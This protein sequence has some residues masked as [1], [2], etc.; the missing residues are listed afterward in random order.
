MKN[1]KTK[2]FLASL[3]VGTLTIGMILPTSLRSHAEDGDV[4]AEILQSDI[5]NTDFDE[6]TSEVTSDNTKPKTV[7]NFLSDGLARLSTDDSA[8]TPD[9]DQKSL[10][11]MLGGIEDSQSLADVLAQVDDLGNTVNETLS[12]N[13][14]Q[15]GDSADTIS[16]FNESREVS[17]DFWNRLSDAEDADARK[18]LLNEYLA[19]EHVAYADKLISS[20]FFTKADTILG[21]QE[22]LKNDLRTAYIG[23]F[24]RT[25]VLEKL[26]YLNVLQEDG[27][28]EEARAGLQSIEQ[29]TSQL[30]EYASMSYLQTESEDNTEEANTDEMTPEEQA[31]LDAVAEANYVE[32]GLGGAS[33]SNDSYEFSDI[34]YYGKRKPD[35]KPDPK[36]EEAKKIN[37]YIKGLK[38][39]PKEALIRKGDRVDTY[40]KKDCE[41]KGTE[42]VVMKREKK[43]LDQGTAKIGA[44]AINN[45]DLY[46]GAMFKANSEM[47]DG[48][49]T[50]VVVSERAPIRVLVNL[51]GL[52]ADENSRLV[53]NPNASS[54]NGAM[55]EILAT[56][57]KKNLEAPAN[58]HKQY[59]MAYSKSQLDAAL[60]IK[61]DLLKDFKLDFSATMKGEKQVMLVNFEQ[62]YFT[63]QIVLENQANPSDYFGG[64]TTAQ[65]V[66]EKVDDKN[67]P[68]VIGTIAYGRNIVVKMETSSSSKDVKAAFE[69]S[70]N[71]VD[72]SS[73]TSYKE[74]M[75]NTSFSSYVFG[76]SAG[77]GHFATHSSLKDVDELI[78]KES[79][80]TAQTPGVPLYYQPLFIKDNVKGEVAGTTEYVETTTESFNEIKFAACNDGDYYQ[81]SDLKYT[82][83]TGCDE[84]GNFIYGKEHTLWDEKHVNGHWKD[85]RVTIPANAGK[86]YYG[87][88]ITMG[89][90]WPWRGFIPV[91]R[92]ISVQTYGSCRY[93]N[94][95]IDIDG[96]TWIDKSL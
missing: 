85:N 92:D 43:S 42:W 58:M 80:F 74:I 11:D 3:L 72:I 61:T 35:P 22:Q 6:N 14:D 55:N 27:E 29:N 59:S 9:F 60:S 20:D 38:Y 21:D 94:I 54:I 10:L 2:R 24:I 17:A 56:F 5:R 84:N 62:I 88:D 46:P 91:G 82:P 77:N 89:S 30:N 12:A 71:G 51:P 32:G 95:K 25:S 81:V 67:P 75:K 52:N 26:A 70:I 18:D 44:L 64:K 7:T 96:R 15:L 34:D 93:S 86:I 13:Q 57:F 28:N 76:G 68:V 36:A 1:N 39:E 31:E 8:S 33:A 73:N 48:K 49:G 50:P 90:D 65:E 40:R 41:T 78:K 83:I 53:K 23:E 66:K 16:L 63:A 4:R 19:T 37:E 47:A 87:F 69:A 45:S 79:K